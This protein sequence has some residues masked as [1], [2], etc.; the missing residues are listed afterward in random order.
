MKYLLDTHVWIWSQED[1]GRLGNRTRRELADLA[2]ERAVSP[3]STLEIARL[4]HLGVLHL[5]HAFT[6]W[7]TLSFAH[8]H[9]TPAP[10]T[11]EIA[12]EAYE[13][14]GNFH[15]DPIDR[16][17]VAAARIAACQLEVM[18]RLGSR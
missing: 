15:K 18:R 2:N 13:L 11:H 1:P 10:F 4:L 6:E 7:R 5:K 14:P 17:L 12:T 9:A 3:I 8:L 16:V